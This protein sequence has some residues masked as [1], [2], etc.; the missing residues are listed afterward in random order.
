MNAERTLIGLNG[1]AHWHFT[2]FGYLAAKIPN[3]FG[4]NTYAKHGYQTI[5]EITRDYLGA[6]SK[7]PDASSPVSKD[8]FDL[9]DQVEHFEPIKN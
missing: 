8:R 7:N 4:E 2:S 3:F 1:I 5:L 9:I 6:K